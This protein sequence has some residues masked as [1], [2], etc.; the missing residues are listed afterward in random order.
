MARSIKMPNICVFNLDRAVAKMIANHRTCL[1]IK[2]NYSTAAVMQSRALQSE[3]GA[4]LRIV[5]GTTNIRQRLMLT[6]LDVHHGEMLGATI[7][8]TLGGHR[9]MLWRRRALFEVFGL[10]S[11]P[12]NSF[13]Y[14]KPCIAIGSR[15]RACGL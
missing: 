7:I 8:A 13:G 12:Q 2:H 1:K 3:T 15:V 10:K 11:Y 14:A 6:G 4:S 9:E 5:I